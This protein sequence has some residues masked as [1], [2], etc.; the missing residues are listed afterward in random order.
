[1]TKFIK[2][3]PNLNDVEDHEYCNIAHIFHMDKVY[4][5]LYRITLINTDTYVISQKQHKLLIKDSI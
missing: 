5:D 3:D 4:G 2:I 1:M